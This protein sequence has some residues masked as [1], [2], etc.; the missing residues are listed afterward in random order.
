MRAAGDVWAA[1]DRAWGDVA[2]APLQRPYRVAALRLAAGQG[3]RDALL[4]NWRFT[5]PL[6]TAADRADF[7][8]TVSAAMDAIRG[9]NPQMVDT[10]FR[11]RMRDNWKRLD[12][13]IQAGKAPDAS[14]IA[15]ASAKPSTP[16]ELYAALAPYLQLRAGQPID[17]RDAATDADTVEF[18][19]DQFK[20]AAKDAK[21]L[22]KL[23]GEHLLYADAMATLNSDLRKR[24]AVA[25][26]LAAT[27][28][29]SEL[30]DDTWL[31]ARASEAVLLPKL[32]VADKAQGPLS[33]HAVLS[34]VVA[35]HA[36]DPPGLA[37]AFKRLV[38]STPPA[39]AGPLLLE[40]AR[41]CHAANKDR[42]AVGYLDQINPRQRTAEVEALRRE[43]SPNR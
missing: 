28:A 25:A 8:R 19:L 15:M 6:M 33:R 17:T 36:D 31:A 11:T 22:Y 13:V 29:A 42:Q 23:V 16:D 2:A 20:P 9:R 41:A 24:Q 14:K 10:P 3:A 32:A 26:A 30:L 37:A 5:L 12:P 34:A 4:A 7:D 27:R 1:L 21:A 18:F 35:A 39:D 43:I 40:L 38:D